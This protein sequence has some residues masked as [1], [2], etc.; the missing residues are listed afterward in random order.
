[1]KKL[2]LNRETLALVSSSPREAPGVVFSNSNIPGCHSYRC[3]NTAW[4]EGEARQR[5]ARNER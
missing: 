2:T 1:M 3:P 4:A 5:Q